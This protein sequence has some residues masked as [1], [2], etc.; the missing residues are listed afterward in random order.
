MRL[1]GITISVPTI[2]SS[3]ISMLKMIYFRLDN[4]S[5]LG[6]MIARPFQNLVSLVYEHTQFLNIFWKISPTPNHLQLSEIGNI[7]FIAIYLMVFVGAA[8]YSAGTKLS[9]RLDGIKEKIEN[10]VLEE[11]IKGEKARSREEIENSTKIPS[12]SIFSQF[13]QLYLAP[14]ITGIIVTVLLKILGM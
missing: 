13:H 10:Q 6:G 3:V 4:G 5:Q 9:R 7:Y 12:N 11:S 1:I 8:F 14:I 2:I